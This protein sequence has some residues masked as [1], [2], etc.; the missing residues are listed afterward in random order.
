MR[1]FGEL[2]RVALLPSAISNVLMAWWVVQAEW[3]P[4]NGLL[5]A[6]AISASFYSAGM[7]LN[8]WFDASHDAA[9]KQQR[10]IV[11]GEVSA[12]T[13]LRIAIGLI[14]WGL[15]LTALACWFASQ[16][17]AL[18]RWLPLAVAAILVVAIWLYDGPAKKAW[19]APILMGSCRALNVLLAGSLSLATVSAADYSEAWMG[20][21]IPIAKER[22][23]AWL[24][25]AVSIG[26]YVSGVT[27]FARRESHAAVGVAQWSGW[28]IT[29][30]G[31]LS[32]WAIAG[33]WVAAQQV[34]ANAH[35]GYQWMIV[36]LG[37]WV[38]YRMGVAVLAGGLERRK[39]AIIIGLR[40]MILL[41]AAVCFLFC[42]GSFWPAVIIALLL[43]CGLLLSRFSA[44]T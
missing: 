3:I 31:V 26:I 42:S 32:Y 34:S 37:A 44:T 25:A 23:I 22:A 2:I 30:L 29:A 16:A 18:W 24:M 28:A 10:P 9:H 38:C 15:F 1:V 4:V 20:I 21:R 39:L 6:I 12:Q 41:D 36:F 11:R 19:F 5:I 33:W 8:D 35:Q 17:T 14:I 40:T 43:P 7:A 13:A 27:W